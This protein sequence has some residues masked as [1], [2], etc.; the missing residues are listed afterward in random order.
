MQTYVI[1]KLAITCLNTWPADLVT[2]ESEVITKSLSAFN[3][4]SSCYDPLH[5]TPLYY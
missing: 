3:L 2:A 5:V 1:H 4:K